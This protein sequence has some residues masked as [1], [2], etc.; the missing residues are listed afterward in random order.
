MLSDRMQNRFYFYLYPLPVAI[1]GCFVF[2]F[3]DGFGRDISH[4]SY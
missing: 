3:T 2:M 1:V 4:C